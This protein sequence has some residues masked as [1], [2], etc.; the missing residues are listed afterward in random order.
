MFLHGCGAVDLPWPITSGRV[1]DLTCSCMVVDPRLAVDLP[2]PI[3]VGHVHDLTCSCMVVDPRLAV[4]LPHQDVCVILHVPAWLWTQD[5]M[6][7]CHIRT[8][9]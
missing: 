6:W 9:A 5:W 8:C 4:D 3:M 2:W 1:R 7:I